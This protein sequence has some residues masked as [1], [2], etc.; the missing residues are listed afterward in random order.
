MTKYTPPPPPLQLQASGRSFETI[1][2]TPLGCHLF[3]YCS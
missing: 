1:Q 3:G 2:Q